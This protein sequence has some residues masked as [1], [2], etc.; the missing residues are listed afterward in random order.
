MEK[1]KPDASLR[2]AEAKQ[3]LKR[4]LELLHE[5]DLKV[6]KELLSI[7]KQNSE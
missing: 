2:K 7:S 5:A 6:M 4:F 3:R 1:E